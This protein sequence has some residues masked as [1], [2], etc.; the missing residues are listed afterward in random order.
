MITKLKIEEGGKSIKGEIWFPI[1]KAGMINHY[2]NEHELGTS[3][4]DVYKDLIDAHEEI[5]ET[6]KEDMKNDS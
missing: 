6:Y 2:F 5:I 1:T 3:I 4:E